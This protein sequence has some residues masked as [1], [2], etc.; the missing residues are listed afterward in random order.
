MTDGSRK[1]KKHTSQHKTIRTLGDF[2]ISCVCGLTPR[3]VAA[4]SLIYVISPRDETLEECPRDFFTP[5]AYVCE[6]AAMMNRSSIFF[7][8]FYFFIFKFKGKERSKERR[9]ADKNP[10]SLLGLFFRKHTP[11][12]RLTTGECVG[13]IENRF[14]CV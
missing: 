10:F 13:T 11:Q 8:F 6:P 3:G 4:P 12:P 5:F 1:K 7:L 14:T 9:R 2:Y